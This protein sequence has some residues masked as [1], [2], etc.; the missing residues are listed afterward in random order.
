VVITTRNSARTIGRCLESLVPYYRRGD[1][2][3]IVLVDGHSTDGTVEIARPY[4]VTL[5]LEEGTESYEDTTIRIL[6]STYH[7]LDQGWRNA[8]GDLVMFLDS[9]AYLGEDFFPQALAFFA[10]EKLGALGCWAKA[11]VTTPLTET[12]G[13]LW[14]FHG[15]RIRAIQNNPHHPFG[16]LYRLLTTFG[17]KRLLVSG[18]CYIVRQ[19]CLELLGGHDTSGDV[20]ISLGLEERGWRS[21]WWVDAPIYHLPRESL[22]E[23]VRQRYSW[24]QNGAYMP[25]R[26]RSLVLHPLRIGGAV[27]LGVFLAVRFRAP[28]HLAALPLAEVS[29][30]AGYVAGLMARVREQVRA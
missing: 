24:S 18:P 2:A 29:S 6:Y 28:R 30:F 16:R 4:P 3:E 14:S 22:R 10:D 13:Q 21:W 9:D 19:P 7:A 5:L 25:G 11:W 23:V 17:A 8:S 15:E 20:G 12:I 27:A 1:I 26:A